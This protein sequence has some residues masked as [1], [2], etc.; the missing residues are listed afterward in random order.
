MPPYQIKKDGK[1]TGRWMTRFYYTNHL[2]KRTQKK[3]SGFKSKAEANAFE[4]EF[5]MKREGSPE[6]SFQTLYE[7]YKE[8]LTPRIK[9]T[10]M[11]TKKYAIEK[12]ILPHFKNR[13]IIEITPK[14]VR[15]WQNWIM[16]QTTKS[17]KPL[18]QTYVRYLH[19]QLTSIFGFAVKFYN[20]PSNPAQKAGT[21]GETIADKMDFWTLEEFNKAMAGFE[22]FNEYY[23]MYHLLFFSGMRVGELQALTL[24]DFDFENKTVSITKTYARY[25]K[26]DLITTPKTKKS[27]RVVVLPKFLFNMLEQYLDY[28]NN[29]S[30]ETRLYFRSKYHIAKQLELAAE[31]ANVKRIR[32]HDLRHSHASHLIEMGVNTLL[33]QERLGHKDIETTLRTY[34]HLYPDKQNELAKQLE[35]FKPKLSPD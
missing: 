14:D 26:T 25:K 13:S 24:N 5:I 20:L 29:Y 18:T 27:N 6:L 1:P 10:T 16:G 9:K 34:S 35:I 11:Q 17:G 2:G 4:R 12:R 28:L 31:R 32:V 3:Q 22:E 8:D 15:D 23:F 33:I 21:I 7:D 19:S 30:R